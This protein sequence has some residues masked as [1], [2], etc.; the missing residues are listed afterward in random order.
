MDELAGVSRTLTFLETVRVLNRAFHSDDPDEE[1][2]PA[3]RPGVTELLFMI[4]KSEL[5]RFTTIDHATANLIV[6]T[7]EVGSAAIFGL[8]LFWL[9]SRN[10]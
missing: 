7:A 8:G 6:R 9:V 5:Q 4:P 3:T 1:R 10:Y 2:I